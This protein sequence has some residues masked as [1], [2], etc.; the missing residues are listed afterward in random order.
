MFNKFVKLICTFFYVGYFP[1]ASGTVASA[2]GLLIYVLYHDLPIVYISLF[3][4]ITLIGFLYSGRMEIMLNRKDPSC[5]V[6][7]E[8]SGMMIACFLLPVKASVLITAFFVFRAFDMFKIYP[9]QK[10]EKLHGSAGIMLDDIMAG[11]YTNIIM[12]SAIRIIGC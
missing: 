3:L 2:V 4:L 7:D 5:V 6:I 1:F 9:A 10:F 12:H 11:I 8:V